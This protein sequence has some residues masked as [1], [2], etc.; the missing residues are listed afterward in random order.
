MLTSVCAHADDAAIT[1]L[2]AGYALK[3]AGK[4]QE[5]LPHFLASYKLSPSA[6]SLLN[7]A[8]CESRTG[9]LVSAKL[10]AAQGRELA[11]QGHDGFGATPED[12]EL[13]SVA[14]ELLASVEK[15][16]PRLAIK[17]GPGAPPGTVL[18]RDGVRVDPAAVAAPVAVNPGEHT[19]TAGAAG[20]LDRSVTVT[21]AEG[22]HRDI[23][24]DV[25]DPVPTAEIP[26]NPYIPPTQAA[27]TNADTRSGLWA[28]ITAT[29]RN[30]V[31]GALVA[32][33]VVS[34][35][36]GGAFG[37]AAIGK[38]GDSNANGHCDSTGC[39]ATGK[40]LRN[41]ALNDATISTVL[42]G[43]GLVAI[44]GGVALYLTEPKPPTH[45]ATAHVE[46]APLVGR[47]SGGIGV[48]VAW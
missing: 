16:M 44:G 42:F 41:T 17:L 24:L 47:S 4:C 20:R 2:K 34:L 18:L 21:L 12:A 45:A 7:L 48:R 5:A 19:V 37:I 32:G 1:E 23:D 38:N 10:H 29:P 36:V 35:V 30:E 31:S 15:R 27:R 46:L 9:D 8:D 11:R 40:L 6:K 28:T 33:G 25:G 3:Q 39:D 43:V 14:D 22:Q 26:P 13:V